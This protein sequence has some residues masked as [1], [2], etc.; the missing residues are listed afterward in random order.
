MITEDDHPRISDDGVRLHTCN[1]PVVSLQMV[2]RSHTLSPLLVVGHLMTNPSRI[3]DH[4]LHLLRGQT[5]GHRDAE[6]AQPS[7][8]DGALPGYNPISIGNIIE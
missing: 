4:G 5:S 3:G 2:A 1:P 6:E 7:V 8:T